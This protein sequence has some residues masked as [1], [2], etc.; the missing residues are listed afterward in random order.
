MWGLNGIGL[1]MKTPRI[2]YGEPYFWDKCIDKPKWRGKRHTSF[3]EKIEEE[4]KEAYEER[5]RR[6]NRNYCVGDEECGDLVAVEKG[7]ETRISNFYSQYPIFRKGAYLR[8]IFLTC[9]DSFLEL[10]IGTNLIANNLNTCPT[11]P[12][13]V[14]HFRPTR[15]GNA[16]RPLS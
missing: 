10:G 2:R 5:N 16:T 3:R 7:D 13:E 4:G 11:F 12:H 6:S 9:G 8:L 1:W 15:F 14:K